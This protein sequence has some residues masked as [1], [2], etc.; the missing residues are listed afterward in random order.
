MPVAFF[1]LRAAPCALAG[2]S[3]SAASCPPGWLRGWG[4][5]REGDPSMACA[6]QS[7]FPREECLQCHNSVPLGCVLDRQ[8][9]TQDHS[10][11]VAPSSGTEGAPFPLMESVNRKL[12]TA[13]VKAGTGAPVGF[14]PWEGFISVEEQGDG[15]DEEE[16]NTRC[17]GVFSFWLGAS[18]AKRAPWGFGCHSS[19]L[20]TADLQALACSAFGCHGVKEDVKFYMLRN[21]LG[22]MRNGALLPMAI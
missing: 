7:G 4:V 1:R 9:S 17:N 13:H 3:I 8:L 15:G 11:L 20:V 22:I 21:Q 5:P 10:A 18:K 16:N 19:P 14:C 12:N 6:P 2:H